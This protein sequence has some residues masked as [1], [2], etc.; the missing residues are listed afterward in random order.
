MTEFARHEVIQRPEAPLH[1]A[2]CQAPQLQRG[3]FSLILQFLF[4]GAG[5]HRSS[6]RFGRAPF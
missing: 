1:D 2:R 4:F 3:I 6:F 5:A